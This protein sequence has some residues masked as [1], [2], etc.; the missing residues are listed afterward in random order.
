[1]WGR[2]RGDLGLDGLWSTTYHTIRQLPLNLSYTS[3]LIKWRTST[4]FSVSRTLEIPVFNAQVTVALVYDGQWKAICQRGKRRP[5][6][7]AA[8][9][10][11]ATA[12]LIRNPCV[13]VEAFRFL[14]GRLCLT[15]SRHPPIIAQ[16]MGSIFGSSLLVPRVPAAGSRGQ[17]LTINTFIP[18]SFTLAT[19]LP[20][21]LLLSFL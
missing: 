8:T 9:S 10:D 15:W 2:M 17:L 18:S 14:S 11:L 20:L 21:L 1:M 12:L 4:S 13:A 7:P 19:V 5:D 3:K 16:R 6:M